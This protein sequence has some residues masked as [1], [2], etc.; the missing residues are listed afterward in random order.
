MINIGVK[1]AKM[2][3]TNSLSGQNKAMKKGKGNEGKKIQCSLLRRGL[4]TK[5]GV[6]YI[7]LS[8]SSKPQQLA[9]DWGGGGNTQF[10]L[11]TNEY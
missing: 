2:S 4:W 9:R 7:G 10:V 1:R 3:L 5:V 11:S 8:P 6:I